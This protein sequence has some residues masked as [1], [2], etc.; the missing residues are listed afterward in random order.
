M[1]TQ[2]TNLEHSRDFDSQTLGDMKKNK[3]R[4]KKWLKRLKTKN[5]NEQKEKLLDLQCRQMRDN[6]GPGLQYL[7]KF[8]VDL[9]FSLNI[10]KS[11]FQTHS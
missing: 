7:L 1:E 9:G 11:V 8:K 4:W 2:L 5:E 6:L 10:V 3:V